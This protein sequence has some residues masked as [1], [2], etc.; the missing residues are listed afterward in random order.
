AL[1]VWTVWS[2]GTAAAA[3]ADYRYDL[4]TQQVFSGV[5]RSVK[6]RLWNV[7]QNAAVTGA[8]I[9]APR[10]DRSPDSITRVGLP[11]FVEPT[12][13]YGVYGFRGDLPT[14]GNWVLTF[15]AQIP[16]EL[17]TVQ[18]SVVVAVTDVAKP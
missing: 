12:S 3:P 11:A 17:A 18:G 8:A 5:G 2:A 14:A 4:L 9:S 10:L 16:G 13:E 15:Q 6:V 1:S 7:R